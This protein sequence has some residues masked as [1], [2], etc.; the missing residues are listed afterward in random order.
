MKIK[1]LVLIAVILCLSIAG[2][3]VIYFLSESNKNIILALPNEAGSPK[4]DIDKIKDFCTNEF[5]LTYEIQDSDRAGTTTGEYPVTVTGTTST[6]PQILGLA[7]TA[8]SFFPEQAWTGKLKQAVLNETAAFSIF[9]NY[10]ITGSRFRMRGDTWLV[11]GVIR[12]GDD[13][14]SRIYIPSSVRGGET[15]SFAM[16]AAGGLDSAYIKNSLKTLGIRDLNYNFLD[17]GVFNR[18]FLERIRV[19]LL[20]FAVCLL[21]SLYRPLIVVFLGTV[22]VLKEKLERFYP[23]EILKKHGKSLIK[24]VIAGLGMVILPVLAVILLIRLVSICLPWQDIPSLAVQ[25]REIFYLQIDK[26]QKLNMI[27]AGIFILSAAVTVLFFIIF[28]IRLNNSIKLK[29]TFPYFK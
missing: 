3:A 11:T 5:P 28:N 2:M 20:F 19:I 1:A 9:G 7:M 27:S 17:F 6:Y 21:L 13:D 4:I 29:K 10:D 12:D 22:S 18:L 24:T 26:I 16:S 25:N 15:A 8:G 14:R 23:V